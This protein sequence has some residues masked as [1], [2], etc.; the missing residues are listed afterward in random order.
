[1]EGPGWGTPKAAGR[2]GVFCPR[3]TPRSGKDAAKTQAIFLMVIVL[4]A[5]LATSGKIWM[6]CSQTSTLWG[7]VV[8]GRAVRRR[9]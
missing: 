6:V 9:P 8:T 4:T 2:A 3:L 5:H 7:H 1:M